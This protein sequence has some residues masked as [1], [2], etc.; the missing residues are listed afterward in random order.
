M[1][2]V[3]KTVEMPRCP[4]CTR[5][6]LFLTSSE[7][8]YNGRDFGPLWICVPCQAWCGVHKGT[9]EPLG[10]LADATLRRA[11]MSV[12]SVFDPLWKDVMSAYQDAGVPLNVLLRIGRTRAYQWLAHHL[13]I[14]FDDCHV[15]MFDV[16]TCQR[17]VEV[18]D[19]L[20]PT[21]S[22][23]RTWAK[24]RRAEVSR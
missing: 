15:G 19:R 23:I 20:K 18:I 8:V 5:L 7:T 12:H 11:K 21:P 13:H 2:A 14:P 22:T 6:A 3:A 10:R 4:Y 9:R 1:N 17:A 16:P 24:A